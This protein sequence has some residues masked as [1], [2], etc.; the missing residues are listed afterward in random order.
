V[1]G[2]TM[3]SAA[4]NKILDIR[5]TQIDYAMATCKVA[6]SVACIWLGIYLWPLREH[7]FW[8]GWDSPFWAKWDSL[9]AKSTA[10]FITAI[11]WVMAAILPYKAHVFLDSGDSQL[12]T[13]KYYGWF[14]ISNRRR[15]LT[16]FGCIAV[17]H[18]CHPGGE[19]PD[20][21][22]GS[23]GLKPTDG[24]AVFWLK[25]FP[26]TQDE[27]PRE[28]YEFAIRLQENLPLPITILGLE[29]L[30]LAKAKRVRPDGRDSSKTHSPMNPSF[31]TPFGRNL[32]SVTDGTHR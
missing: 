28:A 1:K 11:P 29:F 32:D 10:W 24:G 31:S 9:E 19:G 8:P 20:T 18:V 15:P 26:T 21:F 2:K 25:E 6:M 3:N 22:T 12:A 27:M 7:T 14:R 30:D 4:P 23:V 13:V 16:D 17:R 5:G